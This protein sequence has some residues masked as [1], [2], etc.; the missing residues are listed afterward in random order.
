MESN[1]TTIDKLLKDYQLCAKTIK[2]IERISI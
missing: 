1:K 2:D